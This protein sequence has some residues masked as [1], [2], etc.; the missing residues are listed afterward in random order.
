MNTDVTT[1]QGPVPGSLLKKVPGR[2]RPQ[3]QVLALFE[4]EI[5]ELRRRYKPEFWSLFVPNAE[6]M[7]RWRVQLECGGT[8]EV[9]TYGSGQFP[10]GNSDTGPLTGYRFS[11]GEL[12]CSADHGPAQ[13]IY[14]DI[15]EWIKS[16]VKEF[17]AD[18]EE[19]KYGMSAEDW[20]MTRQ[21]EPHSS[22][23]WTVKLSC[24][25]VSTSV[26]TKVGWKADDGPRLVSDERAAQ[27]RADFEGWW[28][29]GGR[30]GWPEEG[31]ERDHV[32]KMIELN[33]PRPEP[34]Q[35]CRACSY[36]KRITGY[37]RIGWLVSKTPRVPARKPAVDRKRVEARL[38]AAEAE[39]ER[40]RKQLDE[41]E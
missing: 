3:K 27:M 1:D 8:R 10:D 17:P 36:A 6:D 22:A 7:Y 26:I 16:E 37:Q 24:G 2:A 33:W 21:V 23:F 34:E 29:A 31:P 40:L 39:V 32:R 30:E 15:V 14:R 25:H 13:K 35:E 19:P 11:A 20:A 12:R 18:P 28:S 9:F 4:E 5:A 41:G 38:A